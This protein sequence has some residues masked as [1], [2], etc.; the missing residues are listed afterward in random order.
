[1]AAAA[2]F[3]GECT[4]WSDDI[5]VTVLV[6][7]SRAVAVFAA[8]VFQVGRVG[9]VRKAADLLIPDRV[10]NDAPLPYGRRHVGD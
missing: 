8:N 5:M 2:H 3:S 10:A 7:A 6:R 1:M 4:R 9:L